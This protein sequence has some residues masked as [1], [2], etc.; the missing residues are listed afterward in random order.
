M[1]CSIHLTLERDTSTPD[2]GTVRA[3][4]IALIMAHRVATEP[5]EPTELWSMLAPELWIYVAR[6]TAVTL[7]G[8]SWVECPFLEWIISPRAAFPAEH[9]AFVRKLEAAVVSKMLQ[10]GQEAAHHVH[11]EDLFELQSQA[12][13]DAWDETTARLTRLDG[14]VDLGQRNY[15]AYGLFSREVGQAHAWPPLGVQQLGCMRAGWPVNKAPE[16]FRVSN[17]SVDQVD[18]F[19]DPSLHSRCFCT[20]EGFFS[21]DWSERCSTGAHSAAH[22]RPVGAVKGSNA[23]MEA[24]RVADVLMMLETGEMAMSSPSALAAVKWS[25]ETKR[26]SLLHQAFSSDLE[27]G[28]G[29]AEQVLEE[30]R[31]AG[32]SARARTSRRDILGVSQRGG[33]PDEEGT[34]VEVYA[35]LMALKQAMLAA[36]CS[37]AEFRLMVC[38]DN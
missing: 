3:R 18:Q 27:G 1:G 30:P 15:N 17:Q 29:N 25:L 9:A 31:A 33:R 20:L 12:A 37:L 35:Q 26:A 8:E 21:V 13:E 7:T 10:I 19:Y 11:D 4:C 34:E 36:G 32:S 23:E 2:R 24:K 22:L 6:A 38:F 5:T 28:P 14:V 16:L